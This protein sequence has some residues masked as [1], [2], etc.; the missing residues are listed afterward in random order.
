VIV[1]VRHQ[2][3]EY[4]PSVQVQAG[5]DSIAATFDNL[6]ERLQRCGLVFERS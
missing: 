5:D 2:Q 1:G 4:Q 3:V 6:D